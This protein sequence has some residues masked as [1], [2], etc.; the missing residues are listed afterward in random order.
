LHLYFETLS[1]Y[2]TTMFIQLAFS[3]CASIL[4]TAS[5]VHAK[6][7]KVTSAPSC[8]PG[9]HWVRA[10]KQSSY[11]RNGKPVSGSFHSAGCDKN[12]RAYATWNNRL[13]SSFPPGWEFKNE[14]VKSWSDEEKESAIEALSEL[15]EALL[16]N[17][18]EGI[19]RMK[20][21]LDHSSNPAANHDHQIVLY[22]AAFSSKQNL[23]RILAHEFA[24]QLYRQFY[25]DEDKGASY[26]KA[27]DWI[28][29][30]MA[31]ADKTIL[32]AKPSREFVE[33]D[34]EDGPA[35][36]FGNN[37]EYFLFNP[38]ELKT[39]TPKIYDWISKRYGDKFKIGKGR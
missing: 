36:D 22:D 2:R 12:P 39:K 28:P 23:S 26:A 1:C 11:T 37:I 3:F 4:L 20:K 18:V 14:K 31:G 32:M 27:A 5:A 17:S 35:E 7:E 13:K 38:K 16:I 24:H 10:H 19:Y 25:D 8:P 33:N 29:V 21:S 15:P 9:E 30:R 34:G 6:P